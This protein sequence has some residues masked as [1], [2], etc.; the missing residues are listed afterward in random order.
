VSAEAPPF[1]T[2]REHV[3]LAPLSTLEVGGPARHYARVH[4]RAGAE[5]ATRWAQERALPLFVLGGGSN[6]VFPDEGFPGLVLHLDLRGES[7][8]LGEDMVVVTAAAGEEWDPLVARCVERGWAGL[9][10][11]SGI[12]GTTG[13]T[14]IQNVG[15]YGQEVSDTIVAVE[16]YDRRVGHNVMLTAKECAFAYRDSALKHDARCR[17]HTS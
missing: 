1:L 17:V 14:P 7:V 13:A 12:P 8:A 15:A 5:A 4:D 9:E 10:C 2:I 6:V 16:A 11:L 3:P